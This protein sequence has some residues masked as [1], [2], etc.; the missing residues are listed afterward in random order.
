MLSEL[1]PHRRHG[2]LLG[3]TASRAELE[4]SQDGRRFLSDQSV[5][6]V[7]I[8]TGVLR[9]DPI[10]A[11]LVRRGL[12]KIGSFLVQAPT[13]TERYE[14]FSATAQVVVQERLGATV[15]VCQELGASRVDITHAERDVIA[16][17]SSLQGTGGVPEA[18]FDASLT[19]AKGTFR[20]D[21]LQVQ[22]SWEFAGREPNPDTAELAL[23]NSGIY[24]ESL[25]QMIRLFRSTNKPIRH[26]FEISTERDIRRV[27]DQLAGVTLPFAKIRADFNLFKESHTI[28]RSQISVTFGDSSDPGPRQV[29]S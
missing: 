15:E 2:I 17:G 28:F 4:L 10:L 9:E 19:K 14:L 5:A 26:S 6:F 12:I 27:A 16:E 18:M 3:T 25:D 29:A 1:E 8:S 22:T 23:R 13:N 24:D 7:D 20:F 11:R 21:G